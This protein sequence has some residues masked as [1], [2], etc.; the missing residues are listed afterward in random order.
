MSS[1]PCLFKSSRTSLAPSMTIEV[2]NRAVKRQDK[3]EN[4]EAVH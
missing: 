4:K 2:P 1:S 3:I